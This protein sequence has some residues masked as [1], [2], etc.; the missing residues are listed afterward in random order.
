MKKFFVVLFS[1][2]I[3]IIQTGVV[4]AAPD[5]RLYFEPQNSSVNPDNS[6]SLKVKIN[7]GTNRVSAIE[8][9]LSFDK[10]RLRLD[11]IG[12]SSAFST[13]L[14]SAAINNT[15]GTASI[16]VGSPPASPVSAVSD[17]VTLNF[18]AKTG[19]AAGNASVAVVNTTKAAALG[20][21]GNVIISSGY[22]SAVVSV[23]IPSPSPSPIYNDA[24]LDLD[25]EVWLSD[26]NAL[27]TVFGQTN[28]TPGWIRADILRNGRIDIYDYNALVVNFG[29]GH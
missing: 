27:L 1:S 9:Y 24:D 13:V 3:V 4:L 15:A 26:Y 28:S 21:T 16:T 20:E 14:K 6:F 7:P 2:L 25:G 23:V 8:L 12:V 10:T 22:G 18:K 17:L 29:F 11:S 19:A 5:T